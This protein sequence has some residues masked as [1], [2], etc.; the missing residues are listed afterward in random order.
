MIWQTSTL[1]LL[2]I[3]FLITIASA[4]GS[5]FVNQVP[6]SAQ[7]SFSIPWFNDIQQKTERTII[8]PSFLSF[9]SKKLH[10]ATMIFMRNS[11]FQDL[12]L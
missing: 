4:S 8:S 2:C 3:A 9:R 5:R 12:M 10:N 1:F 7:A 6:I 11:T